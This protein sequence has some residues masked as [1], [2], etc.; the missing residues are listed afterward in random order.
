MGKI[1]LILFSLLL[2]ASCDNKTNSVNVPQLD[3]KNWAEKLGYPVDSKVVMLHADD[4]GMCSEANE[5]VIPYLLNDQI[6]SAAAMVPCPWFNDIADWYKKHP[7][8]DIGLHLTLTSEWK[9]YRWGPVSNPSSVPELIDPEGYLWRGVIDV[10]SRTPVATIEK[11][12]RAQ[13]E[14]AYERG[15]NPGHIDTHMGTLYSK[16]EYTE[17]FFNIAMEYGI[18]A[19]VIE[20][21]PDRVQ[22]F[23]KQGYPITARLIE[24]GRKYTLPKL[25]DFSSVPDGKNYQNKKETFFDLIQNLEPGITEIIFHPSINTEGL[26]KITNSWQQRVWEAKMFSDPEVIQFLKN[27]GIIFTNWKEMMVRFK[28]R[29]TK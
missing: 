20:F 27:E 24:S 14:R 1:P 8:M 22:K 6:Q 4:I 26:K 21:T 13:I 18:P 29:T 11:E 28:E 2:L 7:E 25:D 17:A 3:G 15:I 23:R 9:N 5:A 19:N 10:A 16:V 12:V